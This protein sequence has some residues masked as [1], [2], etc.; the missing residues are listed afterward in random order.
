[1]GL[2]KMGPVVHPVRVALTGK[3][4]GPGLFELMSLLGP[5]RMVRRLRRFLSSAA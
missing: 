1:M 2:E 4:V 5:S 3:T